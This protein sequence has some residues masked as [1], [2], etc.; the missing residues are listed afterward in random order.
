MH[1]K[2]II[3]WQKKTK[4]NF[5]RFI[6]KHKHKQKAWSRSLVC[7]ESAYHNIKEKSSCENTKSGNAFKNANQGNAFGNFNI[8]ILIGTAYTLFGN[9]K[10]I[11]KYTL[12]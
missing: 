3:H 4:P 1:T 7:R 9:N 11:K 6:W 2:T 5:E 12:K 10:D 8:V